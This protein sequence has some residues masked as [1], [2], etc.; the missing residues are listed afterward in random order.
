MWQEI[1][2]LSNLGIAT[3]SKLSK[4]GMAAAIPA[5]LVPPALSLK[6]AQEMG[7][8]ILSQLIFYSNLGTTLHFKNQINKQIIFRGTIRLDD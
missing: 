6:W 4:L 2:S 7:H 1:V 5:T 3:I 8:Q